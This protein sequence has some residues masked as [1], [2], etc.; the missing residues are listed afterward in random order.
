[1]IILPYFA[2][3]TDIVILY[4]TL[5]NVFLIILHILLPSNVDV[6]RARE[7]QAI[8]E[9]EVVVEVGLMAVAVGI[10]MCQKITPKVLV[11]GMILMMM[12]K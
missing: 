7:V 2:L 3:Y 9:V 1:M 12:I 11:S 10:T 5:R 6:D 4:H 8:V